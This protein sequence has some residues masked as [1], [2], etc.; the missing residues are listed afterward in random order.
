M[1]TPGHDVVGRPDGK[2]PGAIRRG[3][4]PQAE[5]HEEV[6]A[7]QED[8]VAIRGRWGRGGDVPVHRLPLTAVCLQ[9]PKIVRNIKDAIP[10]PKGS[11]G[12]QLVR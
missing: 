10:T 6:A 7:V 8:L 4:V 9:L 1:V 11:L 5:P 2:S 12:I 3:T